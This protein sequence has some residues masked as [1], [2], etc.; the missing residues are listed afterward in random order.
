MTIVGPGGIGK[1][2]VALAI[3]SQLSASYRDGVFFVDL[4]PLAD[5]NRV[6]SVLAATLDIA[7]VSSDPVGEI[8]AS[9]GENRI[10]LLVDSC[11]R[12]VKAA[13]VLAES[14]L[15]GAPNV[16]FL[17]TSREPLRAEG[18]SVNRLSPLACPPPAP[19]LKATDAMTYPAVEL[20]VERAAS[21]VDG[22]E[23]TDVNAPI[24]ADI[25]RQLD[26]IALAIELAAA[27]VDAFSTREIAERLNDR[28]RLLTGGRRTA[29]PRHRTLGAAFDWS[30]ELL[31]QHERI[32]L[33]R[34]AIFAGSFSL[35]AVIAVFSD[36]DISAAEIPDILAQLVAK[37]LV[38]V[39]TEHAATRYRLLDTT[40][41]YGGVKLAE[42][43]E[44]ERC[45][46]R[47]A[48]YFRVVFDRALAEWQGRPATEWLAD[49]V[50]QIDNLRVALDWAFS[51]GGDPAIGMALT[52]G[53][54]PL[55]F[56]LSLTD[57]CRE[58]VEH[59]LASIGS[60]G[61]DARARQIMQLYLA[62]GLSRTFTI[63]LAPQASAAWAKA[64]EMAE[65]L[66]EREFQ[67]E[68]LWGLWFCHIGAGEYRAALDVAGQFCDLAET[69]ADLR[70]GDRLIGVPLHCLGQHSAARGR[71]EHMLSSDPPPSSS[72]PSVRFRF[73]QPTAARVL[74]AQMLWLQGFPDQAAG[75]AR[76]SLEEARVA[77]HAISLCDA[78]AQAACPIAV[79]AGDLP[80]AEEAIAVL[81]DQ[82]SRHAL[83]PWNVLGRAW[84]AVLHIRRNNLDPGLQLLRAAIE[85]LR[86]VRFAFYYTGF[87][88]ALA[89]GLAKAGDFVL[90]LTAIDAAIA[91]CRQKEELWY[92]PELLR[93]KGEVLV[94]SSGSNVAMI[95]KLF[96]ESLD[97][98][99]RQ[100]AISWELRTTISL[101]H[102]RR[103]QGRQEEGLLALTTVYDRFTQGFATNDLQAARALIDEMSHS[104]AES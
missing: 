68:A 97:W 79:L 23:L 33:G 61:R 44:T 86:E 4:A 51:P 13:A 14:V 98:A 84:Q 7:A 69:I 24:V 31:S 67:L 30:Y 63:G 93:I 11:E 94:K 9:I 56:Q 76:A 26:G 92:L 99:R 89:E 54:I 42:S 3:A 65:I 87:L 82:S 72:A 8:I 62:L 102:L 46:R 73:G 71:I 34:L 5:P 95:E 50:W 60:Q 10:L 100:R 101:A 35:D 17:A 29:L 32:A 85:D 18:E 39:E 1:T 6:A 36:V 43:Q 70:M 22:F 81:L 28:F 45:A 25:C 20:F 104:S 88:G 77:G 12:V 74:L 53:A 83:D 57:E 41:A 37:S 64:F 52:V 91:R 47:H 66:G 78:L 21:N 15:R 2:T 80:S 48:E 59:A 16:T 38:V 40:R 55:W 58:G 49:Y 90:G 75:A 103:A 19:G 96:S 27:R